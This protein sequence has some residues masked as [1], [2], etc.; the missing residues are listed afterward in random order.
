[1]TEDRINDEVKKRE[2]NCKINKT[3][4]YYYIQRIGN[5]TIIRDDNLCGG[6]K[7]KRNVTFDTK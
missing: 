5:I 6:T 7:S 3:D 1:M 2:N 4:D